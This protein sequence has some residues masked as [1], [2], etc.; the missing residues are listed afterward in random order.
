MSDIH[1]SEIHIYLFAFIRYTYQARGAE[2]MAIIAISGRKG[3]IGKTTIAAN[4][5]AEMIAIGRAVTVFDADPQGSLTAWAGLGNGVLATIVK[6]VDASNPARFRA[7]VQEAANT[8]DRVIIDTPPG[9][10][11]PALLAGLLADLVLLPAGPSSLDIMAARDAIELGHQARKERG[12]GKPGL[13]LV[14]SKVNNTRLGSEL[15]SSLRELGEQVLPPI[16]QRAA[17]AE[18]ALTGLTVREFA[19]TSQAAQEFTAL[20]KAIERV[21]R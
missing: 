14:P 20:A 6:A 8:V 16:G 3:G 19:R 7:A 2:H 15:P 12:D 1:F 10:T 17:V 13:R 5:A 18:A 21:L 9:F 4:L 11:D